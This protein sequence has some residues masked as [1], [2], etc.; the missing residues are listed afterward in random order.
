MEKQVRMDGKVAVLGQ[1]WLSQGFLKL[2]KFTISHDSFSGHTIGPMTR[3]LVM[4]PGAVGVLPYDPVADKIL[5]IEQFRLAAH[6][7]GL[8]A[9]QR[10]IVAGIADREEGLEDL[11]R[12]EAMEEANCEVT[13]L[14]EMFRYLPS[15]GM[16]NEVL[17]LFC[18][19]ID[20]RQIGGLHG[21]A[22]EHEDIRSTLFDAGEIPRILESGHTGN[23]PLITALQWMQL[24]RERVR[25]MWR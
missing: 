5:L 12:R 3:E 16:S 23:G 11:A 25:K 15:P 7:G 4:R 8:P 19:R 6:L 9:W 13:D 14:M 10:E 22:E 20:S 17:V 18:G 1:E 2:A 21:L 24:N